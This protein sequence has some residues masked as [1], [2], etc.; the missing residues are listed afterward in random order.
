MELAP[1]KV[2]FKWQTIIASLLSQNWFLQILILTIQNWLVKYLRSP[3]HWARL[4]LGQRLEFLNQPSSS[5]T[6]VTALKNGWWKEYAPSPLI[7]RVWWGGDKCRDRDSRQDRQKTKP[8]STKC[9]LT[10]NKT[11]WPLQAFNWLNYYTIILCW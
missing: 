11:I 6:V 8:K 2:P 10:S 3:P 5:K 9:Y 4:L 1:K 7:N